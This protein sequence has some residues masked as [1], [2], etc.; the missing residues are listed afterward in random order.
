M[1]IKAARRRSRLKRTAVLKS[2]AYTRNLSDLFSH[3]A[4]DTS[5]NDTNMQYVNEQGLYLMYKLECL[6]KLVLD[7]QGLHHTSWQGAIVDGPDISCAQLDALEP[8]YVGIDFGPPLEP[9]CIG[10]DFSTESMEDA[11]A[12]SP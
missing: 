12:N 11:F 2:K 3:V 6:E 5:E 7:L 4:L 8:A 9:A 1:A 10:T